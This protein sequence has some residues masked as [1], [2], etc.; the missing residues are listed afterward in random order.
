MQ[1][2]RPA[3]RRYAP[4]G[5]HLMLVHRPRYFGPR[6]DGLDERTQ[7]FVLTGDLPDSHALFNDGQVRFHDLQAAM[8]MVRQASSGIGRTHF[9]VASDRV[10]VFYR[11]GLDAGDPGAW[12]RTSGPGRLTVD[13]RVRPDKVISGVPRALEF[14]TRLDIDGVPAGTASASLLFLAPNTH[15]SHREHMRHA[16]LKATMGHLDQPAA[17]PAAVAAGP[18]PHEVGRMSPGNVLL[19]SPVSVDGQRLSVGVLAPGTWPIAPARRDG[20]P[21]PLVLEALRQTALL[22][23]HRL[24][25]LDPQTCAPVALHAH[26]RGH[27]EPDLP[28]RCVAVAQPVR[29][30]ALG[31]PLIEVT[32]TLT[33]AGRAVTEATVSVV[34]AL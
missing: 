33:Q 14:E 11:F 28:L 21:S 3:P 30:D 27:T 23:V 20:A 10:A 13:M 29:R 19:R 25:G 32:L 24:H 2:S 17:H 34:E 4:T 15:R 12:E 7:E 1:T 6:P 18:A 16:M 26:F 5:R 9:G 31:R 22:T 8:A